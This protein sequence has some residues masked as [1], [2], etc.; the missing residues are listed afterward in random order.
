MRRTR[1]RIRLLISILLWVIFVSARAEAHPSATEAT[2]ANCHKSKAMEQ[3]E[4]P[5]A[6]ALALP[7]SN[8]ILKSHP[9]LT[10]R[11]GSYTYV[12]ETHGDQTT[13]S[14]T[15][16]SRTITVPVR[17]GFGAGAQ[18]WVLEHGGMFYESLVSFYPAIDGLDTTT[19]DEKLSP[20]NVEEAFG[21]ELSDD[22]K[23]TCF[24]C[25]ATG[26]QIN[27]K[28]HLES[29]KP[30]LTCERCHADASAH[31]AAISL[32]KLAPMPRDLGALSS[33]GISNYCGQ[34]HRPWDMVVRSHWRGEMNV[35]FQPY[36]LANSR[37]FNGTDPRI[38][39]VACHDPHQN[40][41]HNTS[42]YDAKCLAC[43]AS[44]SPLAP[45]PTSE[46]PKICPVAK[47]N[48]TSCHMP[49]VTLP[50]GSSHLT[51]TDHQIRIVKPGGPYPN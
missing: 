33:E 27:G 29:L 12:V 10:V 18:T 48:C 37:C 8:F 40:L 41:V 21:R 9:R 46:V 35:R 43:H 20:H 19:G 7:G 32:K 38:S 39:C 11:K 15:D 4:T 24:G 49:K 51:F 22:D 34:C 6:R 28:L 14:V 1:L 13:Y 3:R 36:R 26:T 44:G 45:V 50:G 25:H 5:M 47:G 16:G 31:M 2:C 42:S 30:G 23:K 17:W